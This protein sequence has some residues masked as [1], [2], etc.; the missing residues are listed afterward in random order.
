M[1]IK[2]INLD[3]TKIHDAVYTG[4]STK[5]STD[6]NG[7]ICV[8]AEFDLVDIESVKDEELDA[9]SDHLLMAG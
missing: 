1:V 3:V 5:L 8:K 2:R 7:K 9:Y 6:R 4:K